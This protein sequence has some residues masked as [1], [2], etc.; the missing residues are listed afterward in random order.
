VDVTHIP[1]GGDGWAHLAAVIDCHDREIVGFEFALRGRAK[2]AERALEKALMSFRHLPAFVIK[3]A[4][5][6]SLNLCKIKLSRKAHLAFL[7]QHVNQHTFL[8][9][10]ERGEA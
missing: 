3:F 10:I 9:E 8:Q 5:Y 2:E 4:Y 7:A 6:I 1:C